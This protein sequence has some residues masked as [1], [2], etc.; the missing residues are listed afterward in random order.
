[1]N[2]ITLWNVTALKGSSSGT[3]FQQKGQQNVL[4]YVKLSLVSSVCGVS[5]CAAH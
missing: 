3:T 5:L 2:T 4:P 1:M